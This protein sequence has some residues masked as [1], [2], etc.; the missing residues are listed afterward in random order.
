MRFIELTS[1]NNIPGSGMLRRFLGK[2]AGI[3]ITGHEAGEAMAISNLFMTLNNFGMAFP[4]FSHMYAI[5]TVCDSTYKDKKI[6]TS[7]CY[8]EETGLLA[9]NVMHMAKILK[10]EKPSSWK[11]DYSAN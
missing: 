10:K 4:P 11:Y 9:E 3:I 6:V 7:G 1:D 8:A 5:N 2:A